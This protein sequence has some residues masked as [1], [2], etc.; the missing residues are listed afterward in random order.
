MIIPL[1]RLQWHRSTV[2]QVSYISSHTNYF[3]TSQRLACRC[4]GCVD[5]FS[6][7]SLIRPERIPQNVF[8]R[9]ITPKGRYAVGIIWSDGHSSSIY[10]WDRL[11]GMV[12]K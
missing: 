1:L 11:M 5:E 8:P 9:T 3:T 10:P 6:G 7:V 12:G 2:A 4:A